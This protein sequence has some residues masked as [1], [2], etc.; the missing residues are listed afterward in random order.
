VFLPKP[1]TPSS[2]FNAIVDAEGLTP[3]AVRSDTSTHIEADF[4]SARVLLAEDNET[5]QFVA[6]EVLGGL[7]IELEIAA[8]GR[9][10]VEM[11]ESKPYAAILMDMQMPEMDGLEATRRI[12]QQPTLR[13]LP[14]IAM[15]A[16]AMKTDV[17]ACLSAGMNDF[18]SKPIERNALVQC[19]RRWLP[20]REETTATV[21]AARADG[22]GS[23]ALPALAGI[24]VAQSV[25]RLGIPLERLRPILLRFAEDQR[26]TLEELRSAVTA[27]DPASARHHAHALAG[28]AGNLG[29]DDLRQAARVL[30]T[31]ALKGDSDLAELFRSVD[32]SAHT[33]FQS[34][35]SLRTESTPS[36]P[37]ALASSPPADPQLLR[38]HLE[39][40]QSV[41]ASGDLSGASATLDALRGLSVP[42]ELEPRL[43]RMKEFVDGY[44]YDRAA[45]VVA[46]L[47]A[48]FPTRDNRSGDNR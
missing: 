30:E 6:L 17:E 25:R 4:D 13:N 12:R 22:N 45:E 33:V 29:A 5:N 34:I 48:S 21:P 47:L 19:L 42:A 43:V 32:E 20:S 23:T 9:E 44:E 8:N 18:I 36:A 16:N 7:G 41:L 39:R 27:K 3:Q 35:E 31:A 15:T 24:D 10:A 28:A 38:N 2:L 40:L 1:I 46:E 14:I 37:S 26:R 11:A